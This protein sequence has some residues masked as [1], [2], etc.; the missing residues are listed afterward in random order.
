M[1]EAQEIQNRIA[2]NVR[3]EIA[4]DGRA[5]NTIGDLLGLHPNSWRDRLSGKI[6]ITAQEIVRLAALLRVSPASLIDVDTP[7]VITRPRGSDPGVIGVE[8]L[9]DTVV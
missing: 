1:S 8:A 7:V 6:A 5:S 3:A 2:A 4:R 9:P